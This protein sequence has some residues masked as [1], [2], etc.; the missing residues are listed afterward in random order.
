LLQ[1]PESA[2]LVTLTDTASIKVHTHKL[3]ELWVEQ[4]VSWMLERPN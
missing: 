1:Y 2:Q 4:S 3:S